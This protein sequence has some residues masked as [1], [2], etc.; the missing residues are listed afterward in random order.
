MA[1][2]PY[3]Y[4]YRDKRREW[5]WRFRASNTKIIADSGESY[6]N[7]ADCEYAIALLKREAPSAPIIRERS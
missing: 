1:R 5:R 6:R 7:Q 4:V 3:F 2:D